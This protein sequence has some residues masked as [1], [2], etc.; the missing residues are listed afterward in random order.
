[1][2]ELS[3]DEYTGFWTE[4][5]EQ[6]PWRTQ[7]DR[8]A[9]YCDGNQLDAEILQ[10]MRELGI[11]PAIEPLIGP[12][13]ASVLGMEVRNRGDWKVV[14]ESQTDNT[15]VADALNFKLHQAEVRAQADVA[16]SNAFKPQ[17]SVGIGWVYVGREEDPFQ[18]PYK[19]ED[20][21]RNEIFWD[22]F[23][24]PDLS[25][26]RFL[27]R[28]R[29]FHKSIPALMFPQH[30]ELIRHATT[31]WSD[32]G[33]GHFLADEGGGGLFGLFASQH[34][35]RSWSIEEAQWRNTAQNRAALCECWY[36][37]WERVIV[38]RAQDG[39]V[40]EFD[41]RNAVHV[42][43]VARGLVTAD[44]AIVSRVRLSWWLGPHKLAD[45]AHPERHGRF[46]YVPFWAM[47][48]DRTGVPYG[49]AR[50]MIYLQDQVNALHS[51][52]QWMM[53]ARRVVRTTGAV[54]GDDEKFRQEVA[55]PDAD[56][57][58]DGRAMGNG[59]IFKVETD[60]QLTE[61]QFRR[62]ADSREALR[63]V[64]GIYSEFQGQNNNTTSGV[65]FNSQV[66]QSNQSLA[67][68][69]DNFKSARQAVGD[70]LLSMII[71]DS[72]GKQEDIFIS[73]GGI[74][75][76]RTVRINA[77]ASDDYG[78]KYLNNDVS[79]VAMSVVIDNI[80]TAA[81]FRQQQL[82]AMSAAFQSAPAQ[83]QPI[84]LPFLLSLM[85]VP[86]RNDLIKAIKDAGVN[87]TPDQVQKQV[88]AAV[89]QALIKAHYDVE[90]EKIRQQQPIIDATVRKLVAEAVNKGVEGMF[91]ATQ[92]AN[93]IAL[94]PGVA[95]V[96]DQMLRSAGMHDYDQPPI[97]GPVP[98]GV[99]AAPLPENTSPMFPASPESPS[100]GV[101]AGIEGEWSA[102]RST[103]PTNPAVGMDRGIEGGQPAQG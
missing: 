78:I 36:R 54:V 49:L 38:I 96:A 99:R 85:D 84:M 94:V 102:R 83:Y 90:M 28:R 101:N 34:Q 16:C 11:P 5:Q 22:W 41:R 76:D 52:S 91:S 55:R 48:E 43:A 63:R 87:A 31:G 35:E 72:I 92:A 2:Q 47:R 14:A 100:V 97:V 46:P 10:R 56:I 6:P 32:Y 33:I 74:V 60:L 64:G 7:A 26:A 1:M 44:Q 79:R 12:V 3:L 25:N 8:E 73:G 15:D 57:I 89:E 98:A 95:P 77:P 9:D 29:W 86:Y 23:A 70:L 37:R 80:P 17:L 21:P 13:L 19:V 69:L 42:S 61:Q 24:K 88:D 65:Q 39:R 68:I 81:S 71:A 62:L 45:I 93:Q 82:S 18:Y 4:I 20:V 27:I 67:D 53:T 51:K 75:A 59:G 50:G 40:A 103:T 66:E 30:E 58:L